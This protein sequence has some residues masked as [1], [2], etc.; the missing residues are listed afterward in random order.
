MDLSLKLKIPAGIAPETLESMSRTGLPVGEFRLHASGTISPPFCSLRRGDRLQA[1]VA[2]G[3]ED[4][5]LKEQHMN[6][7]IYL[8]GLIVVILAIL[9]FLGL[10]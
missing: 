1:R 3:V 5:C 8:V 10:R 7:I 6:G 4:T 2:V 9:S